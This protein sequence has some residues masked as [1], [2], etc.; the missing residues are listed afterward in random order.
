MCIYTHMSY[1]DVSVS[2]SPWWQ[3]I[4]ISTTSTC[5]NNNGI[6]LSIQRAIEYVNGND[7]CDKSTWQFCHVQLIANRAYTHCDTIR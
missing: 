3:Y 2:M 6:K 7:N 4:T 1:N 5:N